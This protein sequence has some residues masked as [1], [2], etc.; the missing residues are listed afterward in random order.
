MR[1]LTS[2]LLLVG[3]IAFLAGC[4]TQHGGVNDWYG[5]DKVAHFGISAAL[6]AATTNYIESRDEKH[7]CKPAWIGFSTSI[8]IGAAKESYDKNVKK[9]RWSW[10]DFSYDVLGATVGSLAASD[11]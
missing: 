1:Q 9:T 10:E 7:G 4:A 2:F 3:I 5:K 6:A 11:C 8:A